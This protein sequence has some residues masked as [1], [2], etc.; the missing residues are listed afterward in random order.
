ML[1]KILLVVLIVALAVVG[2]L[3]G[4][5]IYERASKTLGLGPK[6]VVSPPHEFTVNVVD[7]SMRRY[8]R[9]KM[10]FEYLATK[11]MV[12]EME[13]RGAELRH[14]IIEVLRTKAVSDLNTTESTENL[15]GE[16]LAAV[17]RVLEQGEVSSIFFTE[18]V[19]Q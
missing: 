13:S 19:I 3:W 14:A 2:I 7:P 9:V 5:P 4:K 17:N 6:L 12:A 10:S 8:L 1:K 11:P 18:F 16:L 15:R